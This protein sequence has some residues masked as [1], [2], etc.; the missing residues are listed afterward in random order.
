MTVYLYMLTM[1]KVNGIYNIVD[2]ESFIFHVNEYALYC[3]ITRSIEFG[4]SL[5]NC[6]YCMFRS[7]EEP[8][9]FYK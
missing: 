2:D 1:F 7:V 3:G 9:S 5:S 8:F 4:A 6:D